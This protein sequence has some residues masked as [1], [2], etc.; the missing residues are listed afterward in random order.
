MLPPSLKYGGRGRRPRCGYSPGSAPFPCRL[1]ITPYGTRSGR[2]STSI[3]RTSPGSAPRTATGPVITCGPGPSCAA[4]AATA[5]ASS[6]HVALRDAVRLEELARVLALVLQHPLVG[7]GVQ[8][9][10]VAGGD[11][12]DR[13]GVPVGQPAPAASRRPSRARSGRGSGRCRAAAPGP[14]RAPRRLRRA[15]SRGGRGRCRSGG[16]AGHGRRAGGGVRTRG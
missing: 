8:G 16:R 9:D 10:H 7:D 3:L 1:E 6:Q 15:A 5:I 13:G 14:G 4:V 12:G 2:S 11:H